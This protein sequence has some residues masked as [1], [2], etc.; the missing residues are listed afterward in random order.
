MGYHQKEKRVES[1][2]NGKEKNP[3]QE[4]TGRFADRTKGRV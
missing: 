1:S 2:A 3:R 4:K